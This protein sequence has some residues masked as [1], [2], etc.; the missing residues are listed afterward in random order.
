[1]RLSRSPILFLVL[2]TA[3]FGCSKSTN[4][5]AP[6]TQETLTAESLSRSGWGHDS[7]HVLFS[8]RLTAIFGDSLTVG[9]RAV[10]TDAQTKVARGRTLITVADLVVGDS[11]VVAGEVRSDNSVLA[12]VIL[13]VVDIPRL[14][15]VSLADT[16]TAVSVPDSTF[17]V[18]DTT[19]HVNFRTRFNDHNTLDSLKV[20]EHVHVLA[21]RQTDG[22]LLAAIVKIGRGDDGDG[23]G[24]GDDGDHD[25]GGHDGGEHG[26]NGDDDGGHG[27]GHDKGHGRH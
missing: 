15:F 19:V 26:H 9:D 1:M 24:H 6:T 16:V 3:L 25:G 8:G 12:R 22:S 20:G 5:T 17:A 4:P 11:L 23:E 13:V 27:K 10:K 18:G 21:I 14:Q 2:A 7:T